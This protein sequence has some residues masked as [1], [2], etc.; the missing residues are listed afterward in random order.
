M[1]GLVAF[2]LVLGAALTLAAP[3]APAQQGLG[4]SLVTAMNGARMRA[5]VAT[6][7]SSPSLR[8][9]AA[10]HNRE[11]VTFG[12]FGHQSRAGG[13]LQRMPRSYRR[14]G[15]ILFEGAG[16]VE[17]RTVVAA[18]LASPEHRA[19]LLGSAWRDVGVS[20]AAHGRELLV[21]VD[22]GSHT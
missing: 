12:Y 15:E 6:V 4:A 8:A 21:T 22:F 18:W 17:A 11:M 16:T 19:I 13:L 20:A 3:G 10:A 9:A 7:H 5:G 2:G 14:V 1:R